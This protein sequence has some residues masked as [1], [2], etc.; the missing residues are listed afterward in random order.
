MQTKYNSQ[1]KYDVVIVGAGPAGATLARLLPSAYRILVIDKKPLQGGISMN[2]MKCCGGLLSENAQKVMAAMGLNLPT[3]ILIRPQ[4]FALKVM[5]LGFPTERTYLKHYF[6][7]DR[8]KFEAWLIDL[9][10]DYVEKKERTYVKDFQRCPEGVELIVKDR[11]NG[12]ENSIITRMVV[13]ADGANSV[14]RRKLYSRMDWP[15]YVALQEWY[16]NDGNIDYYAAITDESI[17]DF[18]SWLIPKGNAVI[19]GGAFDLD[20]TVGSPNDRFHLLK[21]KLQERGLVFGKKIHREGCE[22]IRPTNNHLITGNRKIAFIGEA[23]GFISPSSSEGFSYAFRTA[24]A[25]AEAI[26]EK[27][28][29]RFAD[30]YDRKCGNIKGNILAR[31]V[32][33]IGMYQPLSRRLALGSGVGAVK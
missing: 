4:T 7:M 10:P 25:L 32:K 30:V 24:M 9:I 5:D 18:Y 33:A 1:P 26:H 19:L 13:A 17:T 21:A 20:K 12:K 2:E 16:E 29:E 6:N 8:A 28:I 23:G 11:K 27:G 14:F 22:I 15:K 3:D 31:N